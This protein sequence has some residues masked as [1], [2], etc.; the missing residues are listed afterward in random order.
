[1]KITFFA[2]LLL[3]RLFG[4]GPQTQE[5]K[6]PIPLAFSKIPSNCEVNRARLEGY[7]K[8]FRE[9]PG[10][11]ED[12]IIVVA[13]LG[14][15]E[16]L[17]ELNRIRL[18]VVRA[19]LIKELGLREQNVITAYGTKVGGYGRVDIYIGG[20]FVDSLLANREKALCADCCYPEGK[21]Y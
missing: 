7:V 4:I 10:G 13:R 2:V 3:S 20:K 1:M 11:D 21:E 17:S 6:S 12:V 14:D 19:T 5:R 9:L 18:E 16:S 8:Y 15:G